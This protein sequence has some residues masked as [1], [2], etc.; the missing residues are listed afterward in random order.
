MYSLTEIYFKE[1]KKERKKSGSI[2]KKKKYAKIFI[3]NPVFLLIMFE[4]LKRLYCSN[5]PDVCL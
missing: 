5:Y 2:L 4:C 3:N 1:K